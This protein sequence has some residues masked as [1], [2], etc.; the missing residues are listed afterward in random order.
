MKKLVFALML[1]LGMSVL[2]CSCE[3]ESDNT[4]RDTLVGCWTA[5]VDNTRIQFYL[6]FTKDG[7]YKKY[8]LHRGYATYENGVLYSPSP[9]TWQEE[10]MGKYDISGGVMT[11]EGWEGTTRV[12][13]IN[14][15][16]ISFVFEEDG[17]RGEQPYVRIKKFSTK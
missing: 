16:R 12:T 7:L 13:V 9:S 4:I 10:V 17:E 8:E 15:D 14:D 5:D 2:F 3:K 1:V 11:V 6:E